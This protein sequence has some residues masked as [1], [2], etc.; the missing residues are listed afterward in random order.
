MNCRRGDIAI[1]DFSHANIGTKLHP[2]LIVQADAY[3]SILENTLA[4]HR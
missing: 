2:V 3:N 4:T 1:A